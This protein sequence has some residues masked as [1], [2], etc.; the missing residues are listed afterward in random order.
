MQEF[1]DSHLR[2]IPS[3]IYLPIDAYREF[4]GAI[5]VQ[6]NHSVCRRIHGHG[7]FPHSCVP[8]MNDADADYNVFFQ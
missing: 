8:L 2:R 5:R 3:F 7:K 6:P 4:Q 1:G